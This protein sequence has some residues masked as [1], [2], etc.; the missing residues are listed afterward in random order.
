MLENFDFLQ[1][2]SVRG[3]LPLIVYE[4]NEVPWRIVDWYI[5]QRPESNLARVLKRSLSYTTVTHDS[6]ELHPWTTW[7]T[8]H[9]GVYNDEHQIRF[10]NQDLSVAKAYPPIW[11]VLSKKGMTVGVFGS[12]QSY[13]VPSSGKYSFYVPD[14]FA[15]SAETYPERYSAFQRIN[16]RQTASDGAVASDVKVGGVLFDVARLPL[17]GVS[18]STFVKL[19]QHLRNERKDAQYRSR[20]AMLQ[21]PL[22]FDVFLD[23]YKKTK[24]QF[25]TFFTNHVAGAM[26]RY[27]RYVFPEDFGMT[28][29][30]PSD[31]FKRN[32]V[33][34]AMDIADEQIGKLARLALQDGGTL[35]VL[36]S[37]GQE[38]IKRDPYHG[39]LRVTDPQKMARAMG[40]TQPFRANLA[41]HPDF[42]FEFD[43][44]SAAQEFID[45]A[46]SMRAYDG[47]PIWFR[48][49]REGASVNL[50]LGDP[51][52]VL[53]KEAVVFDHGGNARSISLKELGIEKIHRDPGTG[54]HQP[55]GI[56]I[57]HGKD[58]KAADG[59]RST[60]ESAWIKEMILHA[61]AATE[62][63]RVAA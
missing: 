34:E 42:N 43:S 30:T 28:N 26:H 40:F 46:M 8:V 31:T 49:A 56:M 48:G 47:K 21:A 57:W 60:I 44:E 51:Q 62:A 1:L 7:P 19:A 9:R 27:W 61:V 33:L 52:T 37:M 63:S 55:K 15:R 14:T 24:P 38:A 11:E 12:L 58:T 36:S 53:E 35:L 4:L 18:T 2:S 32:S 6:G 3:R 50:A 16:L 17:I 25:S 59:S 39:E 54:Y 23:A 22:A 20:R 29:K 13:P 41:M 45:R 10:L 5:A